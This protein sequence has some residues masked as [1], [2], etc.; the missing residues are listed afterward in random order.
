M[1]P[2]EYC[3]SLLL[4][5]EPDTR[6]ALLFSDAARGGH[7]AALFALNR[8]LQR[9]VSEPTDEGVARTRLQWWRDEIRSCV[10]GAPSHPATQALAPALENAGLATEWLLELA[11]AAEL[12]LGHD[13]LERESDL[14]LHC[15]RN[16]GLLWLAAAHIFGY[17]ER[18]T[19]RAAQNLGSAARLVE[20]LRDLPRDAARG[21][22]YLPGEILRRHTVDADDLSY[23]ERSTALQGALADVVGQARERFRRARQLL[24]GPDRGAQR[25]LLILAAFRERTLDHLQRRAFALDAG[26]GL[27]PVRRLWIAWRT[28]RRATRGAE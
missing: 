26:D 3:Q 1:I 16:G 12:E 15:Y 23:P 4:R 9:A 27:G 22:I 24:P 13:G 25:G 20:I 6:L 10:S 14:E 7:A 17:R 21:R 11:D 28:A 2:E 18:D 5:Y 19:L 8:E